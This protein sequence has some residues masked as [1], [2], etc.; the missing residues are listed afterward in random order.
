MKRP[1]PNDRRW[2]EKES[3]GASYYC[4]WRAGREKSGIV[5]KNKKWMKVG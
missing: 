1:I 5:G 3:F 4:T 2:G